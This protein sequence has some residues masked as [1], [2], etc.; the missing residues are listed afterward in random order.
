MKIV[1]GW[2]DWVNVILAVLVSNLEVWCIIYLG[3][4]KL[5]KKLCDYAMFDISCVERSCAHCRTAQKEGQTRLRSCLASL[6]SV[7]NFGQVYLF[8]QFHC[9]DDVL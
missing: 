7:P 6:A 2:T 4:V 9:M 5:V 3:T 1:V 8:Q